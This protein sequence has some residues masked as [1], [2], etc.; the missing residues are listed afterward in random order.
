MYRI[1]RALTT[2]ALVCIGAA[3][4]GADAA[5]DR[6]AVSEIER[7]GG[8]VILRSPKDAGEFTEVDI[9]VR[10]RR[11]TGGDEGLQHLARISNL[12]RVRLQNTVTITDG[13]M[14]HLEDLKDLVLLRLTK[15]R[16]TDAGASRLKNLTNLEFLGLSSPGF[17]D[18]ALEHL[19]GM[20]RLTSLRLD[21][22][23]VT[24]RGVEKLKQAGLL[25]NLEFLSLSDTPFS[26]GGV[27][28]LLEMPQLTRLF[29]ARTR[30]TDK[31]LSHLT[32]LA[33]LQFLDLTGSAVDDAGVAHLKELAR[34][35]SIHLTQTQVTYDGY[36]VLKEAVPKCQIYWQRPDPLK[37]GT[38]PPELAL[39]QLLQ[40]PAG[41]EAS[42]K[43]LRGKVVI[44][45][46][47]A[48]WCR[49]CIQTIP[50]INE[51]AGRFKDKPVQFIAVTTE[52]RAVVERFLKK[53]SIDGWIGL[54][55]KSTMQKTYGVESI[56]FT[57]VVGKKGSIRAVTT[58]WGVTDKLLNELLQSDGP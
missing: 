20:K 43:A 57:V 54:D 40:A 46:F 55:L 44:L 34:L 32:A 53:R 7:L 33:N 1:A 56:P 50:H 28:H 4:L 47:W 58:P 13:A 52:K 51:V 27:P 42:W 24:D 5:A 8:R 22:T 21:N 3:V 37:V 26:D 38:R 23:K 16:V 11:W 18:A 12:R 35:R 15:T 10:G 36:E 31:G 49:P 9:G 2:L 19:S 25:H 6:H 14:V 39:E 48:T 30:V 41:A 29:L 17:T 45:E